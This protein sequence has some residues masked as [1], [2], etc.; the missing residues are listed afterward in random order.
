MTRWKYLI[1]RL[2]I[3]SLIALAVWVGSDPLIRR[4]LVNNLESATGAK[5]EIGHLR[6][7]LNKRQIFIEDLVIANPRDPMMNLFQ[8]DMAYVELDTKSLLNGQVVIERGQTS[9]AVFG[10]PR[11]NSG[12]L[13]GSPQA[14]VESPT[15]KPKTFEPIQ[16]IGLR[17]L[18]QL[19]IKTQPSPIAQVSA[20]ETTAAQ[21]NKFWIQEL[22]NQQSN[23]TALKS[24]TVELKRLVTPKTI[25]PLRQK[26]FDS[27]FVHT[28]IS[29]ASNL[30]A[31][32]IN[33]L[34]LTLEEHRA[35]LRA[36][37]DQDVLKIKSPNPISEFDSD[38]I[39]QLLLSKA[40][41]RNINEIIG[42]FDWFRKTMPDP[43]VDFL[44]KSKRGLD[45]KLKLPNPKPDLLIKSI[46]IEGEG[47]FANRH[48]KFAG[49]AF[50]LTSQPERH[51]QPASFELRAQGDQHVHVKCVLDRRSK[52]SVD[53]L[54]I[55]CPDL[56]V[57]DA[58]LLGEPQSMQVTMGPRSRIQADIKI[59][60]VDDQLS[61]EIIFRHTNVALHVDTLNSLAGGEDAALKINQG[62]AGL[63]RFETK[64]QLSGSF[65]DYQ[66]DLKS[67]LGNRFSQAVSAVL[68]EKEQ[69]AAVARRKTLDQL[70]EA[71]LQKLS[72]EIGPQLLQLEALLQEE[73]VE[74]AD[75]RN[76]LPKSD[77]RLP[78]IR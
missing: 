42:W 59:H 51:D 15:W 62:L 60:A 78:K 16:Q 72:N 47:R 19:P 74:I 38:S 36:A 66:Y 46:D 75:L 65:D 17:W 50:N 11:T 37:Y 12:A 48:T 71:Q 5:V 34:K 20:I 55:V 39:T 8:A 77:S 31:E 69:S 3:L 28:E 40:E 57:S 41:E 73:V 76:L 6:T 30:I 14:A 68:S 7:S 24:R 1:P 61:G 44:P 58:Q 43:R 67:D 23:V 52:Q 70:L 27:T 9:Q 45:L 64:V 33:E 13:Q 2:I 4:V 10:A 25:N 22:T 54:D 35:A 18:D 56:E 21:L 63:N 49:T 26:R 29:S 53:S 32:R